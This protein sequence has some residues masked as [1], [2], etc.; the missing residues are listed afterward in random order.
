MNRV[1]LSAAVLL[2]ASYAQ[3]FGQFTITSPPANPNNPQATRPLPGAD[4]CTPTSAVACTTYQFTFTSNLD[5][6]PGVTTISWS[7]SSPVPSGLNGLTLNSNG[8]L[9]GRPTSP[10]S[11]IVPFQVT[12]TATLPPPAEFP[13]NAT[14]QVSIAINPPLSITTSS[15][16]VALQGSSYSAALTATGGTSATG[17]AGAPAPP[18]YQWTA[19]QAGSKAFPAGLVPFTSIASVTGPAGNGDRIVLGNA[20]GSGILSGILPPTLPGEV[21]T[22][23]SVQLAPGQV[24]ANVYVP[25][26][27]ERTGDFSMFPVPIIDPA[28]NQAF[29]NNRIPVSRLFGLYAFRV[30]SDKLPPGLTLSSDGAVTSTGSGPAVSGTFRLPVSV[31]DSAGGSSGA[32]TVTGFISLTIVAPLVITSPP[33]SASRSILPPGEVSRP[34]SFTF[35]ASGGTATYTWSVNSASGILPPNL[36][37]TGFSG[38]VLAGTPT[39]PGNYPFQVTVTDVNGRVATQPVSLTVYPAVGITTASILPTAQVQSAYTIPLIASPGLPP[40]TWNTL[41]SQPLPP[42]L[43]LASNGT[44]S[45]TPTTATVANV[46]S[47]FTA[48]VTDSLG[49]VATRTFQ[50]TIDPPTPTVTVNVP[51]VVAP[52]SQPSVGIVPSSAFPVDLAGTLTLTFNSTAGADDQMIKFVANSS[53]TLQ[54]TIP[55]N[56][57]NVVVENNNSQL[58][59]GTTAGTITVTPA[60]QTVGQTVSPALESKT[61]TIPAAPPQFVGQATATRSGANGLLVTLSGFCTARQVVTAAFS[62]GGNAN[63]QTRNLVVPQTVEDFATW[64]RDPTSILTGTQFRLNQPFTI[65]G[66]SNDVSSVTVILSSPQGPSQAITAQ[67]Q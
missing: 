48:Q 11:G 12:A 45:G 64:Y 10:T 13:F 33:T 40:Y 43:Q 54:F 51:D 53:R 55:A 5:G 1:V 17:V 35:S 22:D 61:I 23:A 18:R 34:Y 65:H 41:T 42:G 38:T 15:L 31:T 57:T 32:S 30:A 8:V 67:I 6:Q 9:S 56:T 3:V 60:L 63:L 49:G 37:L 39:T 52:N 7:I 19:A 50:L 20:T 16:P 66:N 36:A 21:F 24:Y 58:Q 59:A 62:F 47:T 26:A 29:P 14:A 27:A 25:T 4:L 44:L 28:T 2:C 46:P